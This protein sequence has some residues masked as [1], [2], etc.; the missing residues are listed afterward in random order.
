MVEAVAD[1]QPG[2]PLQFRAIHRLKEEVAEIKPVELLRLCPLLGENKLQ[3]VSC[4]QDEFCPCLGA[5]TDPVDA[6]RRKSGAIGFKGNLEPLLVQCLDEGRSH[7]QQ[8]FTA[9]ADDQ[10]SRKR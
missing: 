8:G 5:D 7:L 3:L 10:W 6:R 4:S 1:C 9:R 2:V